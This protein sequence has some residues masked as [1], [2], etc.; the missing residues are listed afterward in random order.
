MGLLKVLLITILV[1]WVLRIIVRLLLP[2]LMAKFVGK[3]QKEAHRQ[4]E[5]QTGA[6]TRDSSPRPD[7][8][9]RIDYVPPKNQKN[10]MSSSNGKVGE[11]VDFE[12]IK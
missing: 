7:G 4:Y 12:E 3:V 6:Y 8:K 9:I 11:F 5:R 2:Y 1:L 10:S